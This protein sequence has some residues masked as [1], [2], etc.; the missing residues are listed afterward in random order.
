MPP[1]IPVVEFAGLGVRIGDTPILRG[2]DLRIEPGEAVGIHGANGSGKTTLLR[3]AATLLA[4]TEG[5][6]RVLGAD[7]FGSERFDVRGRIGLIGHTPA[8][9]PQ[10]TLEENTAFVASIT[11]RPD[12]LVTEVL[13]KVG[14]AGARHRRV[15]QCSHGM[16]RRAE[17]ARVLLTEP[18]LLLLDE[19]HAGLDP[20]ASDLVS[21]LARR[22]TGRGGA[23]VFVTHDAR[24]AATIVDRAYTTADG[25][26]V[27]GP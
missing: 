22:T 8:L 16:Q 6:G 11:G 15:D 18:D 2:V 1:A 24:R 5:R 19:A 9:Y 23:V 4:P 14:L 26:L 17:F 13:A 12:H 27:P 20:L 3:V 10:L 7:L 25:H 21:A